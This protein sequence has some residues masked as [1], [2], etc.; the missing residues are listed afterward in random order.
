MKF[1]G[2]DLSLNHAAMVILGLGDDQP[3]DWR[4]YAEEAKATERGGDRATRWHRPKT[5]NEK[6]PDGVDDHELAVRRLDFIDTIVNIWADDLEPDYLAIEHYAY[7]M[8]G[9]HQLGEAGGV[10]RLAIARR[11]IPQRWHDPLTVKMWAAKNGNADKDMVVDAVKER[12]GVTFDVATS[13]KNRVSVEDLCDAYTLAHMLRTEWLVRKGHV[14]IKDLD[15][16]E[17]QVFNRITKAMPLALTQRE[18]T[19]LAPL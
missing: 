4:F 6:R 15:A 1:G 3:L 14:Q 7:D 13:D 17:I 2:L 9:G 10:V 16:K 18:W 19:A 12:W 8:T 11:G 5:R